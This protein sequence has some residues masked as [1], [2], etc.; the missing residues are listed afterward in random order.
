MTP[1]IR[2]LVPPRLVVSLVALLLALAAAA[3]TA[4][5][6]WICPPCGLPC[7]TTSFAGPGTCPACGMALVEAGSAAASPASDPHFATKVAILVFTGCEVLDFSGPYEMFGAA[8]CDVYTVGATKDPVTTAMG[9]GVVPKYAFADAPRP[10]VLV[11][12]GGGVGAASRDEA[13]LRYIR[14]VS[15]RDSVTMSVCNGAFILANTGLL[16]G[17]AATTTDHNIPRLARQ[18]PKIRVV[19]DRRYVDNG[20]IVATAGLSAGMDGALH[21]IARLFGTGYAEEVALGEEYDWKT[22]GGFARAALA[23]HQIPELKLDDL[24]LLGVV[25]TEGDRDRWDVVVRLRPDQPAEALL[26]R[27]EGALRAGQW[28]RVA[29]SGRGGAFESAWRFRGNDGRAW[30]GRLALRRAG[31]AYVAEIAVARGDAKG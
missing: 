1:S 29:S 27:V 28:T 21:V 12:P 10:D 8:G 16:D 18:Y 20:R 14:E 26:A 30:T 23:D 25:R 9:L 3:P 2:S 11:I 15:G 19:S 31:G 24:G 7:D 4:Q 17:L 6:R 5:A 13:T 22:G